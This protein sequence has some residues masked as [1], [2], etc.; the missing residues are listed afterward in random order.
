MQYVR[1]GPTVAAILAYDTSKEMMIEGAAIAANSAPWLAAL[2]A[3]A[4]AVVAEKAFRAAGQAEP[5]DLWPGEKTFFSNVDV[6]QEIRER[7]G[8]D[9]MKVRAAGLQSIAT[10]IGAGAAVEAAAASQ[11]GPLSVGLVTT[12]I[13]VAAVPTIIRWKKAQDEV[14][15]TN[16][17]SLRTS[18]AISR[19]LIASS[20]PVVENA[21]FAKAHPREAAILKRQRR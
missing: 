2:L 10:F 16:A 14:A 11:S 4:A 18:W 13:L 7:A 20:D 5:P 15:F 21:A 1:L 9:S 3:I 17:D 8:R 6:N 12:G 19:K